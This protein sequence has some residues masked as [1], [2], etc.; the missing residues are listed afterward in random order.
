MSPLLKKYGPCALITGASAGL[1]A[2][3]ARYLARQGFELAIVAR[4]QALLEELAAQCS[5]LGSPKIHIFPMDLTEKSSVSSLVNSVLEK[6]LDVGLLINNAG[7]GIYEK[8]F[9]SSL[10][11]QLQVLDLNARVPL[12]LT[13]RMLPFMKSR[14]RSGIIILASIVA[15][16]PSPYFANYSG[17]KGYDLLLAEGLYHELKP[18]HIDVL[19]VMPGLTSTEFHQVAGIKQNK[20]L[21]PFRRADQVVRTSFK[22]LGK[23]PA[24][25]DGPLNKF[26]LLLARFIPRKWVGSLSARILRR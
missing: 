19:G 2:E 12:E 9:A 11:D 25:V 22:S 16:L 13:H 18:H 23:R 10:S 24:V 1:G 3:Y 26:F 6:S 7:F 20:I 17:T 8:F 15:L 4:R 14:E 21:I 5:Q